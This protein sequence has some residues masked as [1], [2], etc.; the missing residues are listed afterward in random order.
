MKQSFL[1]QKLDFFD[2]VCT[3]HLRIMELG[4]DSL[5]IKM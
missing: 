2:V 1:K 3:T 4:N 5:I